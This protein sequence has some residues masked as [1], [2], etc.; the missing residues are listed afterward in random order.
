MTVNINK[1]K[2]FVK[3]IKE[4]LSVELTTHVVVPEENNNTPERF[5]YIS[6]HSNMGSAEYRDKNIILGDEDFLNYVLDTM[7]ANILDKLTYD[8]KRY[9]HVK[10]TIF[11]QLTAIQDLI[12]LVRAQKFKRLVWLHRGAPADIDEYTGCKDTVILCTGITVDDILGVVSGRY[13]VFIRGDADVT[14]KEYYMEPEWYSP[15]MRPLIAAGDPNNK[16]ALDV[17]TEDLITTA[18]ENFIVNCPLFIYDAKQY[19]DNY[20]KSSWQCGC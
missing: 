7:S 3:Q 9:G 1:I 2:D 13:T 17:Y 18:I 20:H 4:S 16:L 15:Q 5:K 11:E 10:E 19:W 14:K 8:L 12:S 6:S